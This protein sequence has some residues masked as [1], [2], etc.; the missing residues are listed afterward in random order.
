MGKTINTVLFLV[1]G[2]VIP[3]LG[4]PHL[5]LDKKILLLMVASVVVF[6][7]QPG[8]KAEEAKSEQAKDQNTVWLILGLSLISVA[9]PVIEWGYFHPGQHNSTAFFTGLTL[10]VIG[11]GIRVWA[12]QFLGRFFTATVQ[13]KDTHQLVQSGPYALVRHPSYLGAF[14][15]IMGCAVILEAW[16]TMPVAF[17]AMIYAYYVRIEKEEAALMKMFGQRYADYRQQTQRLFPYIW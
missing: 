13:I 5:I 14:I 15:A 8:L 11:V 4:V 7:T 10:I 6:L 3:L 1:L 2:Y 16:Y 12:I 17:A 9:L